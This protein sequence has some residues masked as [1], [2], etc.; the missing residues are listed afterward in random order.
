ML[1]D[2]LTTKEQAIDWFQEVFKHTPETSG[3]IDLIVKSAHEGK[4]ATNANTRSAVE[5][6]K[7]VVE[8]HNQLFNQLKLKLKRDDDMVQFNDL[9]YP[10]LEDEKFDPQPFVSAAHLSIFPDIGVIAGIRRAKKAVTIQW[11]FWTMKDR[12]RDIGENAGYPLLC[13]LQ[14]EAEGARFHLM[15]HSFGCIFVSAMVAGPPN[16]PAAENPVRVHSLFLVQGA[17]SHWSFAAN[18]PVTFH[19]RQGYFH[20]IAKGQLVR[21]VI[22]TTRS[23]P[24]V[25]VGKLYPPAAAAKNQVILFNHQVM[26]AMPRGD[27]ARFGGTG[28]YGIHGLKNVVIMAMLPK[29]G[30]YKFEPGF[31]YNLEA[32]EFITGHSD[33]DNDAVAHAF[34]AVALFRTA[35]TAGKAT[36]SSTSGNTKR[37]AADNAP[38]RVVKRR[39]QR[40]V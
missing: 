8:A 19:K 6:S 9:E 39:R 16:K 13:K 28:S 26:D 1:G 30:K 37:P 22:V 2:E 40:D 3:A 14:L 24:D 36:D 29:E 17:L 34:W 11:S 20:R 4:E 23:I 27:K 33:I 18:I 25:A 12:A 10:C 21:G 35:S 5:L 32:S 7:E 38:A 31:I 15:G